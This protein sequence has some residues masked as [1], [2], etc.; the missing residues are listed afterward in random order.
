MDLPAVHR[1]VGPQIFAELQELVEQSDFIGGKRVERFE[2]EFARYTG[3]A[4]AVGLSNG[5]DAITLALKAAGIGPGDEVIT[6]AHTF[7]ATVSTVLRIG[8]APVLVDAVESTG[9]IDLA[10]LE[11]A[12]TPKTRA[13]LPVHL[14]GHVVD[15]DRLDALCRSK[16]ATLIQD[17]AQAH[18][19]LWRGRKLGSY[20]GFQTYSFYPGKNLGAWG[21]AGAT[22]TDSASGEALVRAERNHGRKPGEKYLHHSVGGNFRMDPLQ[23]VV[24]RHKLGTLEAKN[25]RRRAL[26]A[27]FK[28]ALA[29]VGDICFVE[30]LPESTAVHH[31]CVIR[32]SKREALKAHLSQLGVQTGVHYPIP[33]HLQPALAQLGI[34]KGQLPVS[35]RLA[36]DI[37]SLPFFPEMTPE[38]FETVIKGIVSFY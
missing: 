34:K 1:E 26:F 21:D 15:L 16:G 5:T 3:A 37:L 24:L 22:C 38:Q 12:W 32:T 33:L 6:T 9:L 35:E 23:A 11:A 18:G 13:V 17:A 19:A 20:S 25:Q 30:P 29:G 8:A 27:Q 28:E 10:Q 7:I 2:G 31:L 36:S 4:H 14:Y